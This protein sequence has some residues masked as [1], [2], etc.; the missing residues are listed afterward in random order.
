MHFAI[1]LML[2]GVAIIYG[3]CKMPDK[4]VDKKP[5]KD[6]YTN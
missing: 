2:L 1:I 4:P 5:G 6:D 3:A